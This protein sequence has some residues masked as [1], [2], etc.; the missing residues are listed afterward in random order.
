VNAGLDVGVVQVDALEPD[1]R[2]TMACAEAFYANAEPLLEAE[3][4]AL[5]AAGANLVVADVPPLAFGAAARAGVP[6]VALTNFTWDW[7][8]DDYDLAL[9]RSSGV[10][11][12]IRRLHAEAHEG[13]RLPMHGGFGGFTRVRDLPLVARRSRRDPDETRARLGLPAGV[14]L[15]LASFGGVGMRDL[16][17]GTAARS[18]EFILLATGDP[19]GA[20]AGDRPLV[21]HRPDGVLMLDERRLYDEGLRYED[22]VAAAD[23]V[24]TKPGYGIIAECIANGTAMLYTSRG[25]FAEYDVLVRD[26][27]RWVRCRFIDQEDLRAGR[28]GAGVEAL[29]AQPDAPERPR[30]DGAEVAAGW[31]LGLL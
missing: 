19:A 8:Y 21:E 11:D 2:A 26:M 5:R 12:A 29:L 22:V 16:P 25:R 13:W 6:A 28:W 15:V 3:A 7:I 31:A 18:G 30:V 14:P 20:R 17:L 23:V 1:L 9:G 4:A 24:V 10:G 27:P